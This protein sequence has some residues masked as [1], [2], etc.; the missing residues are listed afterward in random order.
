M[1]SYLNIMKKY[2]FIK[3]YSNANSGVLFL[4]D[5]GKKYN[6]VLSLDEKHILICSNMINDVDSYFHIQYK[7]GLVYPYIPFTI[8]MFNEYFVSLREYNLSK[9]LSI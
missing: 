2:I 1:K 5:E 4:F 7:T 3:S 8:E 6:A 9:V